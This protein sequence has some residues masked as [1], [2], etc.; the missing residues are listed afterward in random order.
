MSLYPYQAEGAQWLANHKSPI[1]YLADECGLGKTPQAV[2]ALERISSVRSL[3]LCP[4]GLRGNWAREIERWGGSWMKGQRV[5]TLKKLKDKPDVRVGV[6]IASYDYAA[7]NAEALKAHG[8]YDAVVCDEAHG[9]KSH[10]SLRSKAILGTKGL[11]R[12]AKRLWLLSATPMPNNPSE[13]WVVFKCAGLTA[14]SYDDWCARYCSGYWIKPNP[15][16]PRTF[17]ITGANRATLDELRQMVE[18]SGIF[19]RR[20]KAEVLTQLPPIHFQ[21]VT[22]PA[23]Q[24][25]LDL[26][27][28]VS[29]VWPVDDRKNL[30]AKVDGEEKLAR[31]ALAAADPAAALE[32]L[33]KSVV[34]LRRIIG[35]KK[36][37]SV[38]AIIR[39]ELEAGAYETVV[40]VAEFRDTIKELQ[41]E[42]HDFGVLTIWGG[43]SG[44][45]KDSI[46]DKFQNGERARKDGRL[47]HRVI[48]LNVVA[49]GTGFTLTRASRVGMVERSYVVGNNV[50]AYLRVH[51]I[52]QTEPVTVVS[53]ELEDSIDQDISR[54]LQRKE[55]EITKIFK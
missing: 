43:M 11:L 46:V 44:D 6:T 37:R 36:A 16:A 3:I 4:G 23:G 48:I 13:L 39:E 53:Y 14:M 41:R 40:L 52:G 18:R 8:P 15:R 28:L 33:G 5:Q 19:L 21:T 47:L 22:V 10:T 27:S 2:E 9:L 24:V 45:E 7:K 26:T 50:Q 34:T 17:C 38:A 51:R 42:L 30:A 25:E 1:A 35:L 31:A 20:K 55:E 32:G 54:V 49:G 29:W 12:A